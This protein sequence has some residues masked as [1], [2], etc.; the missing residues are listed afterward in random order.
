MLRI[1]PPTLRIIRRTTLRITLIT[2]TRM[3]TATRTIHTTRRDLVSASALGI[4]GNRCGPLRVLGAGPA[5]TV[6]VFGEFF[7]VVKVSG[8]PS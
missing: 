1:I 3:V 6:V 7:E 4:I 8:Q 2:A 5:F